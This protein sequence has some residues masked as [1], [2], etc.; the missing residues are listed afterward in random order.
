METESIGILIP[1]LGIVFGIGCGIVAIICD[2]FE[3]KNKMR[4]IEKAID[5]GISLEGTSLDDKKGL[6][7][8]YRSGMVFLAIGIGVGIFVLLDNEIDILGIAS[9]PALIGIALIINDRINYEM[10]FYK[11][12]D[13]E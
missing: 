9:I 8:P 1:I 6:R 4:V 12:S 5:K 3:K 7:V 13:Q 11:K 10:L 2:Y